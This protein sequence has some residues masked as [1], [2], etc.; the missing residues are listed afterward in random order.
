MQTAYNGAK[1]QRKDAVEGSGTTHGLF[2]GLETNLE[3]VAWQRGFLIL[4]EAVRK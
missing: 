1:I 4:W 2:L 3:S